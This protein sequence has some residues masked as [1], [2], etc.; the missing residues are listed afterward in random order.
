M[1]KRSSFG[2]IRKRLSDITNLHSQHKSPATEKESGTPFNESSTNDYIQQLLKQNHRNNWIRDAE[3]KNQTSEDPAAELAPCSV[4]QPNELNLGKDRLKVLQHE[5]VC[6]DVLFKAKTLELKD[7]KAMIRC[8]RNEKAILAEKQAADHPS[9]CEKNKENK[10]PQTN[11]K[12]PA[13]SQS[14]APTTSFRQ[15][16]DKEMA[17][18]KRRCLRRQSVRLRL[19]HEPRVDLFETDVANFPMSH[20]TINDKPN[21]SMKE[22]KEGLQG[23]SNASEPQRAPLGRPLRRAAENVQTYKEPSLAAKMRRPA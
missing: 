21:S 19:N 2:T 10:V 8:S 5:L 16:G 14:M 12:R 15:A 23:S 1:V 11:V 13:R 7:Q 9:Q 6:K 17:E 18:N 4:Q 20:Q 22:N 3:T